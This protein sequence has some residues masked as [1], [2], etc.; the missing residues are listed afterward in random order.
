MIKGYFNDRITVSYDAAKAFVV[1][2]QDM[3]KMVDTI[4]KEL[5]ESGDPEKLGKSS[6]LL[7]G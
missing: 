5:D 6:R 7:E 4:V 3:A 2:Q 1:A